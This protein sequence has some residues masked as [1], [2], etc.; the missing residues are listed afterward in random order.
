MQDRCHARRGTGRT[1]RGRPGCKLYTWCAHVPAPSRAEGYWRQRP[2]V[3][4]VAERTEL[5]TE[6]RIVRP[7]GKR[8]ITT[9]GKVFYGADGEP[10]PW[11]ER[12]G[13]QRRARPGSEFVVRLPVAVEPPVPV[14]A[15]PGEDDEQPVTRCRIFIVDDNRISADSLAKLLRSWI[16]RSARPTM[17]TKPSKRQGSGTAE[18]SACVR[19]HLARPQRSG[20]PLAGTQPT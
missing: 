16:T 10:L 2:R 14:P 12:R 17:E 13:A 18:A 11:R 5:D 3:L 4:D 8:W 19:E 6:F 1:L 15:R 9:K 7:D 20:Y